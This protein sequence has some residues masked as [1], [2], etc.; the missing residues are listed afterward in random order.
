MFIFFSFGFLGGW[1]CAFA[2][3][4][5][6]LPPLLPFLF[7]FSHKIRQKSQTSNLDQPT[8]NTRLIP[9]QNNLNLQRRK[10]EAE[11]L[12]AEAET[13]KQ[14]EVKEQ[15]EEMAEVEREDGDK[16]GEG[17]KEEKGPAV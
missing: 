14:A 9:K 2:L 16:A 12:L 15:G 13:K 7:F 11:R 4:S 5:V 10:E 1:F 6:V 8:T 3:H 17:E